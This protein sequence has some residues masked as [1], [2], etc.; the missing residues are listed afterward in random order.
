VTT[1]DPVEQRATTH[2]NH[3]YHIASITKVLV[4]TA[5]VIAVEKEP[6]DGT[7]EESLQRFRDTQNDAFT[8][9]FN[10]YS[11]QKINAFPG[12]PTIY[13]L[14]VH[15]KGF[16]SSNHRMLTPTGHP[17]MPLAKVWDDL[18]SPI[19]NQNTNNENARSWAGYS[20]VN[21]AAVAMAIEAMWDGGLESFMNEVLFQPL[22]MH[23]T[24]IGSPINDT[25]G[26]KGWVVDC[27]GT[28]HEI[29]RP[30]YQADGA[31]AAALGVY[32][33]AHDL[34]IF[35][36]FI[37]DTFGKQQPIPGFDL[38]ALAT[39]L[40]M[41]YTTGESLRFTP[42]GLYTSLRSST[43]G[44]LSTNRAQFPDENFSNYSIVADEGTNDI[45][46][47]YMAGSAIA[48]SCATALHVGEEFN[49]AIVVLTNTSGPV[50][51]ADH[52]L[53]LILQRMAKWIGKGR[54]SSRLEQPTNVR[55]MVKR[56][57]IEA[58]QKWRELELAHAQDLSRTVAVNKSING[59]FKGEGFDQRL[60]ISTKDNGKMYIAVFG[61]ITSPA[62]I[63]LELVWIDD[64]S[65]KMYIPPH[66]SVDWLGEG[67]WSIAV[68]K[69][70]YRDQVVVTLVRMTSLGEDRFSRIS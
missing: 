31:E 24:T 14:L 4:A 34:D 3:I 27:S 57:K 17:T 15:C 12:N 60:V 38:S 9:V 64:S 23:S 70:E 20:N 11:E 54:S 44:A 51:S 62:Q 35:F 16:P 61:P 42:L 30:L 66:L 68:F 29:Q 39:L 32:S 47:Y 69:V 13:D 67:D 40:R 8:R 63:E 58:L 37:T 56:N 2:E 26:N 52:I 28:P 59:V 21:Y 33:T 50:D 22:G 49:F 41:T 43:I 10:E 48:C 36:K 18:L 25:S 65:V 53:R 5:V 45:P 1:N 6:T 55:D 19:V 46:V 7:F